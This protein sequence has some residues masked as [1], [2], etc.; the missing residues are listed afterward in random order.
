M[1]IS[2]TATSDNIYNT[3]GTLTGNRDVD[4]DGNTLSFV[5]QDGTDA[6]TLDNNGNLSIRGL[7]SLNKRLTVSG[8]NFGGVVGLR[9]ASAN[10]TDFVA[11]QAPTA[12]S[13]SYALIL[14]TSDGSANQVLKTDGSGSLGWVDQPTGVPSAYTLPASDGTDGQIL[15]TDGNGTLSFVDNDNVYTAD[16]TIPSGTTRK[17]KFGGGGAFR[18][19]DST[20]GTTLASVSSQGRVTSRDIVTV[21]TTPGSA[22]GAFLNLKSSDDSDLGVTL[23]AAAGM[24]SAVTMILPTSGGNTGQVLSNLG[25]AGNPLGF[26]DQTSLATTD[27][28]LTGD[29]TVN[30]SGNNLLFK[31][32]LV[33]KLSYNDSND[34]W[35]F[36]TDVR[37]DGSAGGQIKLRE[38]LMGGTS[39]VILKAP[40]VNLASDV[41][42]TLPQ[43]DGS[44]GQFLKTDGS[45]N[46]SFGTPSGG[47]GSS[48]TIK[49]F[50]SGGAQLAFSFSRYLPLTGD[51]IEQNTAS[52]TVA[53]TGMIAPYDGEI[54]KMMARCEEVLGNTELKWYKTGDGTLGPNTSMQSVTVNMDTANKVFTYTYSSATFSKGDFISVRV[55]PANDPVSNTTD[56]NYIIEFE[57]DTST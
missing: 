39:G 5:S 18:W 37:F 15:E 4:L 38:Q 42:F 56:F 32:G 43:A 14:P 2:S 24:T 31:D 55:D 54:K 49:H 30:M 16:G 17:I 51:V 33:S 9:E 10:G 1:T 7:A 48:S 34:E 40:N 25:G 3:N 23:K 45:G 47:G 8:T 53:R 22:S 12:L 50:Y 46:L 57:F 28:T 27:M 13:A 20:G 41:T 26:V 6:M 21:E 52:T 11:L 19:T 36:G 29:R 35:V 44:S